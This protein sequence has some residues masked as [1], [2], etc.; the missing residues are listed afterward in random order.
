MN[1]LE[2][3]KSAKLA[4]FYAHI[5]KE[6][7][8]EVGI[9]KQFSLKDENGTDQ[10]HKPRFLLA[11]C[12][13]D[14]EI[15]ETLGLKILPTDV[16]GVLFRCK[17]LF[18]TKSEHEFRQRG[19]GGEFFA[20]SGTLPKWTDRAETFDAVVEKYLEGLNAETQKRTLLTH[21]SC[22]T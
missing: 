8:K 1:L 3:L 14:A 7:E 15:F 19:G 17:L 12:R 20:N 2:L 22:Y 10:F 4:A 21:I 16:F 11:E 13:A 6:A 9:A 18:A 5:D